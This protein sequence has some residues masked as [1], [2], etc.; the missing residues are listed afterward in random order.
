MRKISLGNRKTLKFVLVAVLVLGLFYLG[1]KYVEGFA[2][3]KD[4][5]INSATNTKGTLTIPAAD[6]TSQTGNLTDILYYSW[7]DTSGSWVPMKN[8]KVIDNGST[9]ISYTT[10]T[11]K[12][13]KKPTYSKTLLSTQIKLPK[14]TNDTDL[15]SGLTINNLTTSNFGTLSSKGDPNN[16]NANI[17]VSLQFA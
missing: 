13:L 8:D 9:T 2:G 7:N 10:S 15:A 17:K 14:G 12:I 3:T 5:Y 6:I 4:Y 1:R 16:N 11:G